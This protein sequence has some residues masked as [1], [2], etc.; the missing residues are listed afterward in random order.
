MVHKCLG[1]LAAALRDDIGDG[2][3]SAVSALRST[4]QL[5]QRGVLSSS[6]CAALLLLVL[7]A[8]EASFA[9]TKLGMLPP[10]GLL[11]PCRRRDDLS[12][13]SPPCCTLQDADR[14][15][16]LPPRRRPPLTALT[17]L[18]SP[19]S[20]RRCRRTATLGTVR[21]SRTRC[22]SRWQS[23]STRALRPRWTPLG[24]RPPSPF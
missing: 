8:P 14:L 2:I 9:A 4:G 15:R 6:D 23:S 3:E 20:P 21:Q 13:L 11:R 18:A 19:L 12:P 7:A 1:M 17:A 5:I 22:C 24:V 10:A 16:P